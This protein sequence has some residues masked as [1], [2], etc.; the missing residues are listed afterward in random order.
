MPGPGGNTSTPRAVKVVDFFFS[1]NSP[2]VHISVSILSIVYYTEKENDSSFEP[3]NPGLDLKYIIL[4]F[5]TSEWKVGSSGFSVTLLSISG[6]K[7][8]ESW[9]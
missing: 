5:G 7:S 8:L 2:K 6:K 9:R 3:C 1:F 4:K